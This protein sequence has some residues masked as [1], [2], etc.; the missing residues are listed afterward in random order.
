VLSGRK[1]GDRNAAVAQLDGLRMDNPIANRHCN[2][3]VTTSVTDGLVLLHRDR[4]REQQLALTTR[5]W[6]EEHLPLP[7]RSD[8]DALGTRYIV[9]L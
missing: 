6:D 4:E 1:V 3:A 2:A 7:R 8:R 5:A 9:L